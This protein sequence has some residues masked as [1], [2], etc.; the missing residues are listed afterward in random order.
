MGPMA[1]TELHRRI[2]E[3]TKTDGTDQSHLDVYHASRAAS[4]PDRTGFLLGEHSINPAH[5]AHEVIRALEASASVADQTLVIGIPCHT[6]H[7]PAIFTV[8]EESLQ[9]AQSPSELVSMT[10]AVARFFERLTPPIRKVGLL[11]TSGTR[12]SRVYRTLLENQGRHVLEVGSGAQQL[13]HEAIYHH[14]WGLKAVSPASDEARAIV[15]EQIRALSELGAEYIVLGCTELP[16][17]VTKAAFDAVPLL[18][19]L[20]LLARELIERTGGTA[21]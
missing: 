18:D 3:L 16:L 11:S 4:I 9:N 15:H 5:G 10:D 2:I 13:L 19:P 21:V 7:A 12:K 8:L 17:A 14:E 1:G 6:F 20:T